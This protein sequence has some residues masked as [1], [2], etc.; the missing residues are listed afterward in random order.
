M[1]NAHCS[2]AVSMQAQREAGT[3]GRG[4]DPAAED[5]RLQALQEAAER[6]AA[7]SAC[8]RGLLHSLKRAF[9]L[10]QLCSKAM[11]NAAERLSCP[12]QSDGQ[13][14]HPSVHSSSQSSLAAI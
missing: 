5:G 14:I 9:D 6:Q 4:A 3:A 7:L 1:A 8:G 13:V 11:S 12:P 2:E 10:A